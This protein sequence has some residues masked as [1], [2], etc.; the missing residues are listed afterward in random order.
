MI[1]LLQLSREAGNAE[2]EL[3]LPDAPALNVEKIVRRVPGSRLVCRGLWNGRQVYAKLF[4]GSEARRHAARDAA[5]VQRLMD[6][7]IVTPPLLHEGVVG[8]ENG[9][10]SANVLI[11]AAI[12]GENAEDLWRT[13]DD[14]GRRQLATRL[15]AV[16]ASHHNAGLQQTDLYLKNFLVDGDRIHTLDGDGIKPL[17]RLFAERAALANLVVL[18]SK[19]DVLETQR[20]LDGLLQTYCSERG[21]PLLDAVRTGRR[22]AAQRR[23]SV[24]AYANRKVFRNCTDIEVLAAWRQ[25]LAIARPYSDAALKTAL[26]DAPDTLL[27]NS[28]DARLKT[29]N[30]CTVGFCTINGRKLV[31]KRYNIK[32]FRHRLSRVWR[33]SRAAD[34]WANAH[35]L[36]MY[37]IASATPVALLESRFGP[38]RGRAFFLAA[39]VEAPDLSKHLE[40]GAVSGTEKKRVM[41][42]VARMMYKLMLLQIAHGDLKASNILINAGQPLLIDLDSLREFRC[43][44]RFEAAHVRDLKRLLKNW[45]DRSQV[46]QMLVH[47]L[48]EVYGAHPLLA[49][50]TAN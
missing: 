40:D 43:K 10:T 22:I 47:A 6:A 41:L 34:S 14:D 9:T 13:L 30:T 27:S 12:D 32:S 1:D 35:R 44:R 16:V 28:P 24:D 20:W 39:Y 31:V 45:Q 49:R 42:E 15:V 38:M 3:S 8:N 50:A 33:P 46:Q 18:L 26:L 17:P 48:Q 5:G 29:G 37:G 19:F 25:F 21:L 7:G 4:I 11:F 23:K 36:G 2:F